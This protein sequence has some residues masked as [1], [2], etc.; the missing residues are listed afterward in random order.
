LITESYEQVAEMHSMRAEYHREL[1]KEAQL[2]IVRAYH[3]DL[4]QRFADEAT[5]IPRR[6]ATLARFASRG[7]Y[8][9]CRRTGLYPDDR[10]GSRTVR[11]PTAVDRPVVWHTDQSAIYSD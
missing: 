5:L 6:A 1:A 3:I 4:A 11:V 7:R 10:A 9:D 8:P 2:D